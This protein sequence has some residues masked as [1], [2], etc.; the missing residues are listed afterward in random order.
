M[1]VFSVLL[2]A[3]ESDQF[4]LLSIEVIVGDGVFRVSVFFAAP[5]ARRDSDPTNRN[6][7]SGGEAGLS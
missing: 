2:M 5:I 6:L 4:S 7:W 3:L 1:D